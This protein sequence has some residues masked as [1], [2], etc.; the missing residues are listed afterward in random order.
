MRSDVKPTHL[1][2]YRNSWLPA[3][4]AA[5]DIAGFYRMGVELDSVS[6]Q[7]GGLRNAIPV[8]EAYRCGVDTVVVI[9]TV[10]SQV[11]FTS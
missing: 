1:P 3:N 4:K 6:Y 2:T 7:G 10:P 8:E 9:G 11:Y 5:S